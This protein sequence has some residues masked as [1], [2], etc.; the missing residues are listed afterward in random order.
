MGMKERFTALRLGFLEDNSEFCDDFTDLLQPS[1][2]SPEC[3]KE[4]NKAVGVD[5]SFRNAPCIR[6]QR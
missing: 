6:L 2:L 4:K 5:Q 1:M 3:R